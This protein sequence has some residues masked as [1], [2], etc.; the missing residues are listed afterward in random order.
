MVIAPCG[1]IE[2]TSRKSATAGLI[3]NPLTHFN[4]HLYQISSNPI[5]STDRLCFTVGPTAHLG[6][7]RWT[8]QIKTKMAAED[9]RSFDA[10]RNSSTSGANDHVVTASEE[11]EGKNKCTAC[12]M[13][14]RGHL[15]QCGSAKCL[16]GLV[17][18]LS[19]RVEDLEKAGRV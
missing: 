19:A 13:L 14:V 17:F 3:R 11:S 18:K 16:Y 15:G 2:V 1:Q 10:P 12:G 9:S 8:D 5:G 4:K 7:P 6:R